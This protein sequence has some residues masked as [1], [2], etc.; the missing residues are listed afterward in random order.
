MSAN[1][2]FFFD[3][4]SPDSYLAATQIEAVAARAGGTARWRPFLLGG[5][6][7]S[8]GNKPPASLPAR[9][10]YMLTDLYRWAAE[11]E[12]P[13]EF[14]STFPMNSLLAMRA[15][16]ATPESERPE[17]ALA[18][19]QAYWGKDRDLTRPEVL[20]TL[21]G[22]DPVMQ[23]VTPEVKDALRVT[24]EEAITRGAFGAP[25]IFVGDE[26]F[27]GNDR[28]QFVEAALRRGLHT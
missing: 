7:K 18:L 27:F 25:T 21:I 16:T 20:A 6:F 17:A 23:A 14:P 22:E 12:V 2:E 10:R 19:F 1:I 4:S 5:V 24:T 3:I 26:M 28:L 13:F 8:V 15:L 9:G 11:Y